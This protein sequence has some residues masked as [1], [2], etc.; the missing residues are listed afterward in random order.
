MLKNPLKLSSLFSQFT[1]S[2]KIFLRNAVIAFL[3]WFPVADL[4]FIHDFLVKSLAQNSA[5]V[6]DGITGV[7][8]TT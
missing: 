1:P 5:L 6:I 3:V 2:Q 4:N 8:P 7:A